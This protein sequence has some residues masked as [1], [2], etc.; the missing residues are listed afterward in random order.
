MRMETRQEIVARIRRNPRAWALCSFGLLMPLPSVLGWRYFGGDYGDIEWF[1]P[2]ANG[3]LLLGFLC[4]VAAAFLCSGTFRHRLGLA[5]LAVV[6]Y[7]ASVSAAMIVCYF[8]LGPQKDWERRDQPPNHAL[9][10]TRRE[11]R[12]CIRC[13][14]CAGSLSLGR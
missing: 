10:R 4:C 3:L 12:G 7:I 14:P 9:Q 5:G 6:G 11:C 8:T 2:I 13:L 1:D